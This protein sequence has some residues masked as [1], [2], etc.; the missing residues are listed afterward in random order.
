MVTCQGRA[1]PNL[2]LK[3][4]QGDRHPVAHSV[5]EDVRMSPDELARFELPQEFTFSAWCEND[6]VMEVEGRCNDGVWSFIDL[7]DE[8]TKVAEAAER[9]R[10]RRLRDPGSA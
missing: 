1:G 3:W 10:L 4:R 7:D 9:D 8:A 2:L 5:D 6:H